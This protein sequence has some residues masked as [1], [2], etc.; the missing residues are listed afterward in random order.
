[1]DWG[2]ALDVPT[3]Y[4]REEELALLDQWVIKERCRV[5]SVLG[6]GGIG[7]SAL[8]VTFM[9]RAATQFGVVIWRSLRD[10]PTCEAL[11]DECLQVLD[12]QSSSLRFVSIEQRI[13]LLLEHLRTRRTLLVLD[14]L[15]M[16][17]D[18][19]TRSYAH[20]LR[21]VCPIVTTDKRDR[22]P[23]LPATHQ[24][25]ETGGSDAAGR[26]P[27]VGTHPASGR[28]GCIC[29]DSDY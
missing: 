15:E 26:E 29:R 24:S 3:F 11:L 2:D 27:L 5:V 16:L 9:H 7:K 14:N 22:A 23:E 6:M 1:M 20:R 10:I 13:N 19:G 18:E 21:R 8:T 4:G 28:V 25:G 17:L 12:P